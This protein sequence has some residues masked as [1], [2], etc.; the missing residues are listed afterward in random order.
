M[1]KLS[2]AEERLITNAVA[3]AATKLL[4]D[5]LKRN[6]PSRPL[7]ET[8]TI[9]NGQGLRACDRDETGQYEVY[10]AGGLVGKH[11]AKL[12]EKPFVV[13]GRKGSAGKPSYAPYG[14]WVIDT[15]YYAQ[16]NDD[17]DLDCEFLFHAISS[18]DFTSDVISTAIPG[19]NRTSIYRYSIPIPSR[20]IQER[21][22]SFLKAAANKSRLGSLPE[23][24][25]GLEKVGVVVARIEELSAKIEEARGLR[26]QATKEAQALFALATS[27]F[28][29]D[30]KR[31]GTVRD[32][33]LKRKGTVRSGPFGSQL[34]HEEFVGSGVAA[35][36]T[37]D[38]QTNH[39]EFKSGWYV[40]PE[41]F[42]ELRRYQVFPGDI[43]CT[44]V[45]AS[46]GRFC[47]APKDIPLAF[48]TKHIQALTLDTSAVDVQFVSY[49]L[50]FHR[51]CRE[52]LFSQ[53]ERSAQP[54][55]N[56]EKVTATELP[57]PPLPEQERIVAEL[58]TLQSKVEYLTNLQDET[59]KELNALMPSIL[60]RAF[61]TAT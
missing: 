30:D 21:C 60:S 27:R 41:K 45:G 42:E 8:V 7:S 24:P 12:T 1:S 32:A 26:Q 18:L 17:Q 20:L 50:N 13:I 19:I 58:D 48:T 10:A 31:W 28:Y 49:M 43:L 34:L 38:V 22:V 2:A 14:G 29:Q 4:F 52:S 51:R 57:L 25:P 40:R 6:F 15:A 39:F 56:A 54:S 3:I 37:R 55:L 35:I 46:I 11:S 9:H 16:P 44:I 59:A 33:V 61:A 23:L 47:V 5:A 36:G 53:V